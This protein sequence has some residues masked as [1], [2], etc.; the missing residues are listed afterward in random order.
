MRIA[1]G[2]R[3][4]AGR[5][6]GIFGLPLVTF[7]GST[8]RLGPIRPPIGPGPGPGSRIGPGPGPGPRTGPG[9]G[10][11]VVPNSPL[12]AQLKY[13]S[14]SNSRASNDHP[15]DPGGSQTTTLNVHLDSQRSIPHAT[16]TLCVNFSS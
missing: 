7:L 9:P 4:F 14:T 2:M 1:C 16:L 11:G 5:G 10:P 8:P 12:R 13:G 6:V 3:G 15:A